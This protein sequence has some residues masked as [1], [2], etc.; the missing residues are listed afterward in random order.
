MHEEKLLPRS[1]GAKQLPPPYR[2]PKKRLHWWYL[3]VLMLLVVAIL[4]YAGYLPRQRREN[5]IAKAAEQERDR[6]P[7][8][9][10]A[11]VK[12][13]PSRLD[14][15]LPGNI[16]PLTEARLY[17]RAAGYVA[18]RYVDMGDHVHAGQVLAEIDT[19]ELDQ[20]VAQALAAVDQARHQATQSRA[21]LES[22]RTQLEL[23]RLTF[24][25]Y[26]SLLGKGAIARQDYDQQNTN[27]Q[28]AAARVRAGEANVGAADQNVRSAQANLARLTALQAFKQVRA[29]FDGIVTARNFDI[30]ALVG[31][32]GVANGELYRMAQVNRLRILVSVPQTNAPGIRV[33]QAASVTVAEFAGQ[34]FNGK[35]TRTALAL[36]AAARTMLTE[37]QVENPR[38]M[39][40]PGMYAQVRLSNE[41]SSPPVLIPGDSLIADARGLR[42]AVIHQE[43]GTAVAQR[44]HLQ[45]VEVG[46]DYGPQIEVASGLNGGEF[47]VVSPGDEVQ[48]GAEVHALL[49]VPEA[50]HGKAGKPAGAKPR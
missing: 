15:L 40:L 14:L 24:D 43:P 9:H 22:Y 16:T 1:V 49:A 42:V 5:A 13:A 10:V 8:V 32:G 45:A 7:I 11:P 21:D 41:R 38:Q 18:K 30:G 50:P 6:L 27:F 33:G 4:L 23:A 25:R 39:L 29:P 17:A 20:Q 37:V 48:E 26:R 34:S 44:I 36:D 19:P 35:I 28:A 2:P 3:L 12:R 46:R 47:V 31:G